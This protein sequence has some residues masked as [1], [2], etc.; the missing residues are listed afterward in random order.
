MNAFMAFLSLLTY[1]LSAMWLTPYLVTHVGEAAFGLISLAGLFTLAVSIVTRNLSRA[2]NRFL[3]IE[4]QKVDG[5]PNVIFSSAFVLYG[6]LVLLQLPLFALGVV[7]ADWIFTIPAALKEDALILLACSAGCY[8]LSLVS[9]VFSATIY[10]KN[11]LDIGN[12]VVVIKLLARVGL[13][14]MLFSVFGAKLRYIGYVDLLLQVF[15]VGMI[16]KVSRRLTPELK[17]HFRDL[18]WGM[19]MPVF[20]MS[21]WTLVTQLGGLLYL[22]CDVLIV[23]RFISAEQAGRYAALLVIGNFIRKLADFGVGQ[24]GPTITTYWA[25]EER[26]QLLKLLKLSITLLSSFLAIPVALVCINGSDFLRLWLGEDFAGLSGLLILLVIH[27]FVNAGVLPLFQLQTTGNRVKVPGI[28]TFWM[29]LLNVVMS[30]VLGVTLGYGMWGVALATALVLTLKNAFF[31]PVYAAG[32]MGVKWHTFFVPL[33]RGSLLIGFVYLVSFIPFGRMPFVDETTWSG[34]LFKCIMISFLGAFLIWKAF[35][36]REERST[37][38]SI[39]PPSL[40]DAVP[41]ILR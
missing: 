5:R 34:F 36:S 27:L 12:G 30:Y 15:T 8:L 31:T 9:S 24:L 39:L 13:I 33:M 26:A 25:R 28:V 19:L 18:D 10:S 29:G 2:V 23:N 32:I 1:T 37:I 16:Y 14:F 40:R 35:L 11:R 22:R 20:K 38:F 3:T 41:G 17:L 7:F 21:F 4:L 6:L